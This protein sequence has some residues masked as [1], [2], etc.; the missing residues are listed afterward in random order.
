MAAELSKT[1][2][3]KMILGLVADTGIPPRPL[4]PAVACRVRLS[5]T[6]ALIQV[7]ATDGPAQIGLPSASSAHPS[8]R[9]AASSSSHHSARRCPK[10]SSTGWSART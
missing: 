2:Q 10:E 3:N 4:S 1:L 6:D 9:K 5:A 8:R 7:F